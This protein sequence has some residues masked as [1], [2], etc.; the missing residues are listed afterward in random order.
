LIIAC[1]VPLS[2]S[3]LAADVNVMLNGDQEV[4]PVSTGAR[5]A[6]SNR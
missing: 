2:L 1:A 5:G 4:P 6:Y 3:A